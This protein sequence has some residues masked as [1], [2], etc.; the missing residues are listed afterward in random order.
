MD[1]QNVDFV[2]SAVFLIASALLA[3]IGT[4]FQRGK[5]L[6][7][8]TLIDAKKYDREGLSKISSAMMYAIAVAFSLCIVGFLL[9]KAVIFF[10]L[11]MTICIVTVIAGYHYMFN[12]KKT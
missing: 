9:N 7:C 12:L 4:Q 5:W 11:C 3:L 6:E 10:I 2:M 1:I 8:I